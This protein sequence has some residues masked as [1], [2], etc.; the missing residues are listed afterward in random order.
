[1]PFL[2]DQRSLY[3]PKEYARGLGYSSVF[4][5]CEEGS[6]GAK[7]EASLNAIGGWQSFL[8]SDKIMARAFGGLIAGDAEI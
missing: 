3:T 5:V 1:V 2:G 8:Y 7:A 4:G 6:L